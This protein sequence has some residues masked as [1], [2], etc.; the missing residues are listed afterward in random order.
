MT[1]WTM[2]A[3]IAANSNCL[4]KVRITEQTKSKTKS[5]TKANTMTKPTSSLHG[6]ENATQWTTTTNSN[7]K[8][9]HTRIVWPIECDVTFFSSFSQLPVLP[10]T[11][12]NSLSVFIASIKMDTSHLHWAVNATETETLTWTSTRT[13]PWAWLQ[14]WLW[15]CVRLRL[16]LDWIGFGVCLV[17]VLYI[18]F[19]RSQCLHNVL[20]VVFSCFFLF[21]CVLLHRKNMQMKSPKHHALIIKAKNSSWRCRL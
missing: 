6:C 15:L 9:Q 16:V 11:A 7:K 1:L 20:V 18:N 19:G 8:T 3:T 17:R 4:L 2:A 13:G 5:K 10:V 21:F 14:L 12:G